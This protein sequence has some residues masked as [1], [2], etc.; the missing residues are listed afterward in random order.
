MKSQYEDKNIR[1]NAIVS[2]PPQGTD[3]HRD[4]ILA[5][6]GAQIRGDIEPKPVVTEVYQM[7]Q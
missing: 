6:Y 7:L 2:A 4:Q 1:C 5:Y 3:S